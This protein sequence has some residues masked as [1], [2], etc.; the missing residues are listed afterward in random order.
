MSK[1]QDLLVRRLNKAQPWLKETA[2]D[3]LE[4][5]DCGVGSPLEAQF[6]EGIKLWDEIEATL[7]LTG[8][9]GCVMAS[10]SCDVQAPVIC[11]SCVNRKE[12][13]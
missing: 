11:R 7:R 6:N 9:T 8:F 10:G 5:P 12:L 13:A 4:Q 3:L 2:T 1:G